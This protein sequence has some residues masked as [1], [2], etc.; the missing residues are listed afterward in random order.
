MSIV[1]ARLARRT[2]RILIGCK[3]WPSSRALVARR[4]KAWQA[5]IQDVVKSP[6][7]WPD[8]MGSACRP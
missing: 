4:H 5:F 6:T 3:P 8:E 7:I 2:I 1:T